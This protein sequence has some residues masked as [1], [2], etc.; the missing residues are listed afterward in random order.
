MSLKIRTVELKH[1]LILAPMAGVTDRAYRNICRKHGAELV[2]TEMVS[3][4]ALHYN[5]VSSYELASLLPYEQNSF[6]Q[7]F[8]HEPD[9]LAEGI[10]KLCQCK[11]GTIT[12]LGIDINMGCPMKKIVNNGEG[13]ALMK[14]PV[15]IGQ[16]VRRLRDTTELPLTVKIRLGWDSSSINAVEVAMIAAENGADAITVHG[17]TREQMYCPEVNINEIAAVKAA[18][19]VPVIA[20]GGIFTADDAM[21][22]FDVTKCDGIMLGRGTMG[23]PWLFEEIAARIDGKQYVLPDID[24]RLSEAMIQVEEMISDKGEHTGVLEAR[25]HL[26]YYIKNT[27]GASSARHRLNFANTK[28]ELYC[29]VNEFIKG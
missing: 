28:E 12:P 15:L 19:D 13:S 10:E 16:I 24:V 21:Q 9:I 1:G 8:G 11:E 4:K 18:V 5:D 3:A 20:N 29:I 14:N 26:S 17:R 23:N 7:L 27:K 25:R 2:V 6:V 22:M